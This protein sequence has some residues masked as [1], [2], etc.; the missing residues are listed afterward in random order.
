M[1]IKHF[2]EGNI[3]EVIALAWCDKTSF[4]MI[5]QQTNLTG[6][7]VKKLMQKNLKLSSYKVW[8]QRVTNNKRKHN[9]RNKGIYYDD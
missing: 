9:T 7:Q 6:D 3:H 8:R 1:D 2:P 4:E 5:K